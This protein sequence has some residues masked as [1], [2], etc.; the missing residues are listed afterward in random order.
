VLLVA[1]EVMTGFGRT[2]KNFAVE[3]WG[4]APDIIVAAKGVASGYAPLGAVIAGAR[5]VEAI[6][7]GSGSFTHGFT[8]N[9]HPV[10]L[11]AGRAVLARMRDQ[12]LVAAANSEN[13][14]TGVAFRKALQPLRDLACVGD[15][16]GLGLLWGVEF[17]QN[18]DKAGKQP[19]PTELNFAGKVGE[20]AR[21]RG[22][23]VYPMQGCVDGYQ[24]DHLLLAPPAI[25]APQDLAWAVGELASAIAECDRN[26][27]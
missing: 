18:K 3:H 16:R 22:V 1:D 2:G 23:L 25:A 8:Y 20:A 14:S 27:R 13:G 21:A 12:K 11:A 10:A 7:S 19:F 9:A 15:V 24:G 6:A 17:V 4:I 26:L 5:V